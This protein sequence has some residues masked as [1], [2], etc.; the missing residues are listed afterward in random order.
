LEFVTGFWEGALELRIRL[1][2]RA[3]ESTVT[4]L[5]GTCKSGMSLSDGNLELGIRCLEGAW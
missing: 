4:I 2:E 1:S 3:W 5:E